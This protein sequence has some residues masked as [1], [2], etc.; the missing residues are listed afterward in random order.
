M[1]SHV[2]RIVI[3]IGSA[4]LVDANTNR[5]RDTWL[6]ALADDLS[7][8]ADKDIILVSSGAI[9]L[10]RQRLG[11]QNQSLTLPQKQ[12]CA[13]AGQSRLTRAYDDALG[14]K[15]LMTAQAL[16][17]LNDTENRR[18]WLNARSTLNTLLELGTIPIINENDTVATD[19]IRY[20]DNDRLAARTA[21]MVGADLL[22][23]LSDIDGLYT[24]DPR[25]D[26]SAKHL[27]EISEISDEI[28]AMGGEPNLETG[29][30]SGGMATKVTAAEIATSAGCDMIICDGRE[31]GALGTLLSGGKHSRFIA[32]SN[33]KKARAQWIAGSL[34]PRGR[35]EIDPGAEKALLS[36]S[37]LLPAG[38]IAVIGEFSKGD[39][40]SVQCEGREIAR[41]LVA[42]DHPQADRIKGLKSG[43]IAK[44]LGYDNGAALIHRDNLVML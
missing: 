29:M 30:G 17:T 1:L 28:R 3:K 16:L 7:S 37:S 12:A 22:V 31:A 6:S 24:A 15:G 26:P 4:I 5:L 10:G 39:A 13:A 2:Q 8:F 11:L 14:A 32:T 21:Q 23:L 43:D 44:A 19:E 25:L 42:Y 20:G 18:R 38:V 33:P 41:G 36:G 27:P 9:A 35:L 34:K 40:V